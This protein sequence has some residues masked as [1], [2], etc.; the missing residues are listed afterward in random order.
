MIVVGVTQSVNIIKAIELNTSNGC[1]LSQ[2]KKKCGGGR[3]GETLG[4]RD[5]LLLILFLL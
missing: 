3:S 5:L 2:E 4:R 1:G